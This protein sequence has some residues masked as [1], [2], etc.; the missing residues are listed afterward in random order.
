MRYLSLL[1]FIGCLV[2]TGCVNTETTRLA[3][4][5][6]DLPTVKGGA[7]V[8]IYTDTSQV[9]CNYV[10]VATIRAEGT[11]SSV[12]D[13]KMI[14]KAK[15]AAAKANANALIM[16]KLATDDPDYNPATFGGSDYGSRSG[17]FLAVYERRPC[18]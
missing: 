2:F 14:G 17:R 16:G 6:E 12:E 15:V 1:L 4:A 10:P 11:T 3:T 8:A 7:S 9:K 13:E 18:E 5:P